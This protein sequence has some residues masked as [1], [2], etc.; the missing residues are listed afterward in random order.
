MVWNDWRRG[1]SR[2]EV[3]MCLCGGVVDCGERGSSGSKGGSAGRFHV[4][5]LLVLCSFSSCSLLNSLFIVSFFRVDGLWTTW[6]ISYIASSSQY[7]C[8]FERL[9]ARET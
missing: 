7:K 3:E 9:V 5:C 6:D 1:S 2:A 4:S 8:V